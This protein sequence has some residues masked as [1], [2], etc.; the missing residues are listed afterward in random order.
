LHSGSNNNDEDMVQLLERDHVVKIGNI[1]KGLPNQFKYIFLSTNIAWWN[2]PE[3]NS[4][5]NRTCKNA[6]WKKW[7]ELHYVTSRGYPRTGD[8][9]EMSSFPQGQFITFANNHWWQQ[10]QQQ[11]CWWALVLLF[12]SACKIYALLR[13]IM[14]DKF[15]NKTWKQ[16]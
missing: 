4:L 11:K 14:S 15:R 10:C 12:T 5:I 13:I 9:K 2:F 7:N 6:I 1:W 3:R 8:V 16:F